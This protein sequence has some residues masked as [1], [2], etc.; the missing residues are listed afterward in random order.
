MSKVKTITSP[1]REGEPAGTACEE[2]PSPSSP[3]TSTETG[4]STGTRQVLLGAFSYCVSSPVNLFTTQAEQI[5]IGGL[6]AYGFRNEWC[7]T[8]CAVCLG[9]IPVIFKINH[10]IVRLSEIN[11]LSL[12]TK[13]TVTFA[14]C[15]MILLSGGIWCYVPIFLAEKN[16][17]VISVIAKVR[18]WQF[19]ISFLP[20]PL[21]LESFRHYVT[22]AF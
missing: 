10:C 22:V 20:I 1:P 5:M 7:V 21:S 4:S 6:L 16:C 3:D 15:N 12:W 11:E 18:N 13:W 9:I 19:I 14:V 17:W 2:K 8:I